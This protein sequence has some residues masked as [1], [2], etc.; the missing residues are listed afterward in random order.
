MSSQRN[1]RLGTVFGIMLCGWQLAP[2]MCFVFH[3]SCL[4]EPILS[5]LYKLIQ[6]FVGVSCMPVF[7]VK[8]LEC[9]PTKLTIVHFA[10]L[11]V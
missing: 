10:G 8:L 2:S 9:I 3:N 4:D 1:G 6:C 11:L 7:Y 5:C